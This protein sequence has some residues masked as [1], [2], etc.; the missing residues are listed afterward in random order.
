MK[1]IWYDE[2]TV[3]DKD[4][5]EK[6]KR[7]LKYPNNRIIS[8]NETNIG[9]NKLKTDFY[10]TYDLHNYGGW[11]DADSVNEMLKDAAEKQRKACAEAAEEFIN[12]HI[13]IQ[14]LRELYIN[15]ILNAQ[16]K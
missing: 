14:E 15:K 9:D 7:T 13:T 3:I 12:Q 11:H 5:W 10:E 1:E 16:I 2:V 8:I 6:I 4:Q